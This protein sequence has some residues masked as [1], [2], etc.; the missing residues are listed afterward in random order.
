[1]C[2]ELKTGVIAALL[3]IAIVVSAGVGYLFGLSVSGSQ[4]NKNSTIQT[5]STSTTCTIS[6]ETMGVWLRVVEST[7]PNGS[8]VPVSGVNVN[9]QWVL[10]CND[11]RQTTKFEPSQTNASG[12]DILSYG[13]GGFYYVNISYP[14]SPLTIILSIQ[15]RPVTATYATFNLSTGNVTTHFCEFNYASCAEIQ[16]GS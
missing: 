10:Y 16:S 6:G 13:G 8:V 4:T 15:T 7:Y 14:Y 1:L 12:W 11:Q 2:P 5:T 3:V 9:G